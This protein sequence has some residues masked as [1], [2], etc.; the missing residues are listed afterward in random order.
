MGNE[1][2]AQMEEKIGGEIKAQNAKLNEILNF[3]KK[4]EKEAN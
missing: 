1:I 2:K 3:I 4:Q